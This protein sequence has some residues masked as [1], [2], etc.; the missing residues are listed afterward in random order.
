MNRRCFLQLSV[1][2]ILIRAR[3][4][5]QA[6]PVSPPR[7]WLVGDS[8]VQPLALGLEYVIKER[9]FPGPKLRTLYRNASGLARPDFFDWTKVAQ[10]ALREGSPDIAVLC[11]GSNDT[12]PLLPPGKGT[13]VPP[14]SAEWREEY[15]RRLSAFVSLFTDKSARVLLL[16]PSFDPSRKYAESMQELS[17]TVRDVATTMKLDLID[18][19]SLLADASG[20]FRATMKSVRGTEV[21]LR[22][23]DGL[24]LSGYGGVVLARS[25]LDM[26]EERPSVREP[27]VQMM[28]K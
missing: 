16:L 19:P 10:S 9:G 21:P 17:L 7:V 11:I 14:L 15:A 8:T 27:V 28:L 23:L 4:H 13:H 2:C 3:A 26:L 22:Q 6:E 12:Q 1:L 25:V 18:A 24:H 20:Q 5:A